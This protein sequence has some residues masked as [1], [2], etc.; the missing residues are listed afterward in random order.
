MHVA[1]LYGGGVLSSSYGTGE[2]VLQV[3][4]ALAAQGINTELSGTIGYSFEPSHQ[5]NLHFI[6]L[7]DSIVKLHRVMIWAAKLVSRSLTY[8]YDI[9]QIESFSLFRTFAL[10]LLLHFINGKMVVVFHDKYFQKDP[11]KSTIGKLKLFL[12]RFLLT[13]F[14][15]SIVP[16]LSLK[17]WFEELH[18]ELVNKKMVVIPNGTPDFEPDKTADHSESRERYGIDRTAYVALFFGSIGFRPN[19]DA[20]IYLYKNSAFISQEFSKKTG[21]KLTFVVA[22]RDSEILPKTDV[23]IPLSFVKDIR[24]LLALPDAIVLPHSPSYSGPHVKTMYAFLS[25]KPVVA[26]DDAVK[27][28]PNVIPGIHFL[29]FDINDPSTLVACLSELCRNRKLGERLA[30]SAYLYSKEFSWASISRMHIKLYERLLLKE[31]LNSRAS[32]AK[33]SNFF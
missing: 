27:D 32:A 29:S 17:K 30:L 28:M 3:A 8:R 6:E 16:G 23:Y 21:R 24:G 15:A 10:F 20:A 4:N 2:R 12:Q 13:N 26:T 33:K 1:I 22:G 25:K 14:D 19:Y 9:V 18:G 7:P 5:A 11:R 31:R